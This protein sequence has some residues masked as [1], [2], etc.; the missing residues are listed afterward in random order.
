MR[1]GFNITCWLVVILALM[2]ASAA[3]QTFDF[4]GGL[5]SVSCPANPHKVAA[6]I[7]QSGTA[8]TVTISGASFTQHS[9]LGTSAYTYTVNG[10]SV[11]NPPFWVAINERMAVLGTATAMDYTPTN[12]N[13]LEGTDLI[14]AVGPGASNCGTLAANQICLTATASASVG[15]TA[16]YIQPN[17]WTIGTGLNTSWGTATGLCTPLGHWK[18]SQTVSAACDQGGQC[19]GGGFQAVDVPISTQTESCSTTCTVTTTTMAAHDLQVGG[20]VSITGASVSGYDG[21]PYT[22]TSISKTGC[23]DSEYCVFTYTTTTTGLGASTGGTVIGVYG[24]GT[25]TTITTKAQP[26]D[27]TPAGWITVANVVPTG[28]NESA[29]VQVQ[30]VNQN[31]YT[32]TY[33]NSTSGGGTGCS[34]SGCQVSTVGWAT[35]PP[36]KYKNNCQAAYEISQEILALGFTG[37]IGEDSWSDFINNSGACPSEPA[38]PTL[39]TGPGGGT[40]FSPT[41]Y[42]SADYGGTVSQPVHEFTHTRVFALAGEYNTPVPEYDWQDPNYQPYFLG[43]YWPTGI[44]S[45]PPYESP[46]VVGAIAD[47]TDFLGLMNGGQ[48]WYG[49]ANGAPGTGGVNFANVGYLASI[50]APHQ[51]LSAKIVYGSG[52]WGG[53]PYLYPNAT[54]YAKTYTGQIGCWA[55][56][57]ATTPGGN[58]IGPTYSPCPWPDWEHNWYGSLAGLNTTLGANYTTFGSAETAVTG[59]SIAVSGTSVSQTLAGDFGSPHLTPNTIGIYE[60]PT[61]GGA[62]LVAGDCPQYYSGSNGLTGC[63]SGTAVGSGAIMNPPACPVHT[64]IPGKP[65]GVSGYVCV[66]T[67]GSIE[68]MISPAVGQTGSLQPAWPS[69]TVCNG[70][71]QTVWSASV[72]M[73]CIG[74]A[75]SGNGTITYKTGVLTGTLN[76][77]LPAGETYAANYTYCG[78]HSACSTGNGVTGTGLE[79]EDGSNSWIGVNPICEVNPPLWTTGTSYQQYYH[80]ANGV[81]IETMV[82]DSGGGWHVAI[83]SGTSGSTQPVSQVTGTVE[84]DG[85]VQ[86]ASIGSAV[87][88]TAKGTTITANANYGQDT[89]TWSGYGLAA[90]VE[91]ADRKTINEALPDTIFEGINFSLQEYNIPEYKPILDAVTAFQDLGFCNIFPQP[92]TGDPLSTIKY[93]FVTAT[94]P[95]PIIA[96]AFMEVNGIGSGGAPVN[97]WA[98]TCSPTTSI[99]CSPDLITRSQRFYSFVSNALNTKG[100][101]GVLQ[102]GGVTWWGI[103]VFQ[104][105]AFGFKDMADNLIDGHENVTGTTSCSAPLGSFTCGNEIAGE[106]WIGVNA[107]TCAHCLV[108]ALA[109]WYGSPTAGPT[110]LNNNANAA[111]GAF[112]K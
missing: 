55:P 15:A 82:R 30:S 88:S 29:P 109:L 94:F 11:S 35:T 79:D 74:P 14:Q 50:A 9:G 61:T 103:Y 83:S 80:T 112:I 8:K 36:A 39:L 95:K 59:A 56:G 13:Q 73:L 87:C 6:T 72:T 24:D 57:A 67:S 93:D 41:E 20:I 27:L 64:Y 78:W 110:F 25:T 102:F 5:N 60:V 84:N 2:R 33:L 77:D 23:P 97:A 28:F 108:P 62:V 85:G 34:G 46:A 45:T 21:A 54:V 105:Q 63:P 31:S 17:T 58:P 111:N 47:D 16:G 3:A 44:A 38:F 52:P 92:N 43:Q 48:W 42:A 4:F 22:V 37:G 71:Q 69:P 65:V 53:G 10:V 106:V 26:G 107:T 89:I 96:E 86:W 98:G 19:S 18:V 32:F 51:T 81:G 7:S 99:Q 70:T 12:A 101:G 49:T 90:A 100:A 75:L 91:Q 66:D 104:S 76:Y 1:R 68:E 40:V